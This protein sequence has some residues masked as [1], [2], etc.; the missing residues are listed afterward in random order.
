MDAYVREVKAWKH[1]PEEADGWHETRKDK[2][3]LTHSKVVLSSHRGRQSAWSRL[4]RFEPPPFFD[5]IGRQANTRSRRL[6]EMADASPQLP[7]AL[8]DAIRNER[9]C[10]MGKAGITCDASLSN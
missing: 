7:E 4:T 5:T 8:F 2:A 9:S 1:C 10:R 6:S 3:T